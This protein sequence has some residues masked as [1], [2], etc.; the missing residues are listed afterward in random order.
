M[1]FT[2]T[3]TNISAIRFWIHAATLTPPNRSSIKTN[4]GGTFGGP[5]KKDR[6]F[7]FLSYEG[8]RI[9]DGVPGQLLNVPTGTPSVTNPTGE[10]AG[11]FSAQAPYYQGVSRT[12]GF[13]ANVLDGRSGCDAAL[14]YTGVA[15]L[16][17]DPDRILRIGLRY[18]RLASFRRLVRT[19]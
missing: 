4:I 2:A 18:S 15:S 17:T 7:F 5:I 1:R 3:C 12:A 19:R 8:R 11:D 9:R 6:T 14:G 16:P 10:F 13:I